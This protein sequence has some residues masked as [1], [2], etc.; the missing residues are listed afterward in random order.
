MYTLNKNKN[1]G[2]TTNYYTRGFFCFGVNPT[3][4]LPY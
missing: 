2:A 3:E 4:N 1:L